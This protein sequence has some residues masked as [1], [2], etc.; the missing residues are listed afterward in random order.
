MFLF[1]SMY[2]DI[3]SMGKMRVACKGSIHAAN[4]MPS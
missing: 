2:T 4:G 3:A 1:S